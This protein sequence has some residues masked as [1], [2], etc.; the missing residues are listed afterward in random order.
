M[1]DF[2]FFRLMEFRLYLTVIFT[3]S[4]D[5]SPIKTPMQRENLI[6]T[7]LPF[8]IRIELETDL[9]SSLQQH[10]LQVDRQHRLLLVLL[11]L[12]EDGRLHRLWDRM[13]S[14]S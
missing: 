3:R 7:P 10:L 14:L 2:H 11:L 13:Q 4:S 9:D 1:I 8:L 6:V 5:W 12:L